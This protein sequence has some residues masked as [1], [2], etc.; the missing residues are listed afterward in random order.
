MHLKLTITLMH[1]KP[2]IGED[3]KIYVSVCLCGMSVCVCMNIFLLIFIFQP[4]NKILFF[5]QIT[6]IYKVNRTDKK[7][8]NI[9]ENI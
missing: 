7:S 8:K 1:L 5:L 6:N 2:R 3:T 4:S 9:T